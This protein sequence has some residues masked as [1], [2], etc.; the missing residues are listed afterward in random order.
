MER[1]GFIDFVIA[2]LLTGCGT[3]LLLFIIR[4]LLHPLLPNARFP[5]LKFL[6]TLRGGK[7]RKIAKKLT[8]VD[9]FIDQQ[10]PSQ[11][12]ALLRT[13]FFLSPAAREDAIAQAR[14]HNQAV[15]SRCIIVSN[16]LSVKLTNLPE[17]ERM[18]LERAEIQSLMLKTRQAYRRISKKRAEAGRDIPSWGKEDFESKIGAIQQELQTNAKLLQA[19]LERMFDLFSGDAQSDVTLH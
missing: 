14:D 17:V 8:K 19:E 2:L 16:Q 13:S 10:K 4:S 6:G 3:I 9:A 5:S 7:L 11:A 12:I 15:L 1:I 18:L